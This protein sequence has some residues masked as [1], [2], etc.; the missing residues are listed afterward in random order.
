MKIK[1]LFLFLFLLCSMIACQRKEQNILS[2][3]QMEHMLYD[4]HLS[5]AM[6]SQF[7]DS[8]AF[9]QHLYAELVYKKYGLT[10][11]E[12]QRNLQYY[13]RQA[14][15]L[16]KMYVN[17]NKRMQSYA[18]G[19]LTE[20]E[21]L[22]RRQFSAGGDTANVWKGATFY[23]LNSYS[24]S[25]H[26]SFEL[27]TD[28]TYRSGDR[29]V[30][31]FNTNWL[32]SEGAREGVLSVR[33]LY[34]NDSVVVKT[35]YLYSS[36]EQTVEFGGVDMPIK[37]ISGFFYQPG[38]LLRKPRL[39]LLSDIVLL[40]IHQARIKPVVVPAAKAASSDSAHREKT[41]SGLVLPS[42]SRDSAEMSKRPH[43]REMPDKSEP[44]KRKMHYRRGVLVSD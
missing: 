38:S 27:Q 12:F 40:R 8:V 3:R 32:Y 21:S 10:E 29:F 33:V 26:A 15:V 43:F 7:P 39:M 28:S 17:I 16:Q 25:S 1:H 18:G 36:G 31:Y 30:M 42:P 9:R 19:G 22:E 34:A 35:Q 24:A 14:E 13:M 41:D 37:S 2:E 11:A 6:A 23:L 44:D 5:Q 4:Y 20:S